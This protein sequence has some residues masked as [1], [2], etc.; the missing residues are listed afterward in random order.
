LNA[1][2]SAKAGHYGKISVYDST[3]SAP[4]GKIR[5]RNL[6]SGA[7]V[8]RAGLAIKEESLW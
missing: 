8:G 4:H 3:P 1:L 5:I 6:L 7:S 2:R